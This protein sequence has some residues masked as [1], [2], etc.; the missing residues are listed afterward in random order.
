MAITRAQQAKQMLQ[1][2][3]MLV[4]PGFGGTRQGYRGPGEYQSGKSDK[5]KSG[6]KICS[7]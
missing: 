5:A 7:T 4:K 1:D 6:P 2:G 3:G